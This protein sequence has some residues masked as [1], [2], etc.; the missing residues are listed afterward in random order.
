MM[1][2]MNWLEVLDNVRNKLEMDTK[3]IVFSNA[4]EKK[5]EALDLWANEFLVK[6][7]VTPNDVL[8]TVLELV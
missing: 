8:N 6:S 7:D 1:P 5:E 4:P 3:I 2:I